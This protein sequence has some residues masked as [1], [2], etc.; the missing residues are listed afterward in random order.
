MTWRQAAPLICLLSGCD[1][2]LWL[3]HGSDAGGGVVAKGDD[4]A[5]TPCDTAPPV[6]WDSFGHGFV[7]T[8][9]QGCHASTAPDRHGAPDGVAFDT[10][11]QAYEQRAR[12]DARVF[13]T[14][15]MPPGGGVTEDELIL[16]R[17]WLDCW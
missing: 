5:G 1:D 13:D 8:H 11:Q 16:A 4:T 15:D 10:E 12:I 17:I 9:C 2:G 3:S 6:D 7:L 14:A